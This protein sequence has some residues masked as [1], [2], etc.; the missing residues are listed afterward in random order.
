MLDFPIFPSTDLFPECSL[1]TCKPPLA[2]GYF[3]SAKCPPNHRSRSISLY[4]INLVLLLFC[5]ETHARNNMGQYPGFSY[6]FLGNFQCQRG[7]G[8]TVLFMQCPRIKFTL[9]VHRGTFHRHTCKPFIALNLKNN[10]TGLNR[11]NT[12]G[13]SQPLVSV[14]YLHKASA[15]RVL[16]SSHNRQ[17]RLRDTSDSALCFFGMTVQNNPSKSS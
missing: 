15:F 11:L 7:T 4:D 3:G 8:R 14:D 1:P 17:Q 13:L 12:G 6:Y 16:P 5:Q 10:N 2:F 9:G